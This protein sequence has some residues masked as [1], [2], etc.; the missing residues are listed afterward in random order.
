MYGALSASSV[1]RCTAI[2]TGLQKLFDPE[3][4]SPRGFMPFGFPTL[5]GSRVNAERYGELPLRQPQHLSRGSEP[6]GERLGGRKRVIP[7]KAENGRNISDRRKRCVAFPGANGRRVHADLH[8]NI[9]LEESK[10]QTMAADV[11]A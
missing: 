4:A 8:R 9:R 6:V 10:V 7:E 3:R 11:V 5:Q 2:E 1:P